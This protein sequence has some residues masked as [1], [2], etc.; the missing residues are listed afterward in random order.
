[1]REK[2][3]EKHHTRWFGSEGERIA[4]EF[5]RE[6]GC[7]ILEKNYRN[8]YG[9]IDLIAEEGEILVFVEVKWRKDP[10]LAPPEASVN[11]R[12]QHRL[13][14]AALGYLSDGGWME[15]PCRFDVVSILGREIEWFQNAFEVDPYGRRR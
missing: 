13:H 5:L 10:S 7:R 14:R 1:M 2:L 6:R 8:A 12:K 11:F 15:R 4:E 3:Q 9:E